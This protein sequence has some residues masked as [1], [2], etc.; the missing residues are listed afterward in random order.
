LKKGQPRKEEGN[1]GNQVDI[2]MQSLVIFMLDGIAVD[3]I[4]GGRSSRRRLSKASRASFSTPNPT[5]ASR[6]QGLPARQS[7]YGTRH[8]LLLQRLNGVPLLCAVFLMV[9]FCSASMDPA[10]SLFLMVFT[11]K[12]L[13]ETAAAAVRNE[14]DRTTDFLHLDSGNVNDVALRQHVVRMCEAGRLCE[15][16]PGM[17]N[18]P[19]EDAAFFLQ[20]QDMGLA[21]WM[22]VAGCT[23]ERTV[24]HKV[25]CRSVVVGIIV[26]QCNNDCTSQ[27]ARGTWPRRQ[28]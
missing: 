10:A 19:P 21:G 8:D 7:L 28:Y 18:P 25:V 26:K 24:T 27:P 12:A 11:A 6:G 16:E 9:F 4:E 1:R 22:G 3:G 13:E 2:P 15:E 14:K 20:V 23:S 5:D 17:M